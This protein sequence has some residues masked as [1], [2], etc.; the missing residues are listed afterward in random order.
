MRQI[1]Q[2]IF[3]CTFELKAVARLR[4]IRRGALHAVNTERRH[5]P[6]S[7]SVFATIHHLSSILHPPSS[8]LLRLF[9]L[10][11]TK[12]ISPSRSS[13]AMRGMKPCCMES[14][15]SK[16]RHILSSFQYAKEVVLF[17]A[18]HSTSLQFYYLG[19]KPN[20]LIGGEC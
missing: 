9:D 17:W 13:Y 8:I 5:H 3:Y 20:L 1:F 7:S 6:F 15:F 4:S 2:R 12:N 10:R 11:N 18:S 19:Y 14:Y 16:A